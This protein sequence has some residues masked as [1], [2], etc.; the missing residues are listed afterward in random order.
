VDRGTRQTY[1][2]YSLFLDAGFLL[3]QW[4]VQLILREDLPGILLGLRKR[5]LTLHN[6]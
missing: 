5:V 3:P 2:I 6:P 1:V 4:A